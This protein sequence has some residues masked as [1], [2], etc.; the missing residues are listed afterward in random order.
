MSTPAQGVPAAA[1]PAGPQ[2]PAGAHASVALLPPF[3]QL[4]DPATAAQRWR[5]WISRL[6][7]Y[8]H[9]THETDGTVKR[10][11]MLHVGGDERFDLFEHLPE[12]GEDKDY[13]EAVTALNKYFDP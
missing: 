5:R 1:P 3:S 6:D 12:N 4:V 7:H 13:D 2:T 8:F 10:S 9:A 11:M